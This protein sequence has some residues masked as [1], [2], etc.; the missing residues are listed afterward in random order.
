MATT[1]EKKY[2][3]NP[4]YQAAFDELQK[5][6]IC[7]MRSNDKV[8]YSIHQTIERLQHLV[9]I[10]KLRNK[11]DPI[12][13][14]Y[15]ENPPSASSVHALPS[16]TAKTSILED[17]ARMIEIYNQYFYAMDRINSITSKNLDKLG[18]QDISDDE[19]MQWYRGFLRFNKA[20]AADFSEEVR[21][22]KSLS[23]IAIAQGKTPQVAPKAAAEKELSDSEKVW[24]FFLF[25]IIIVVYMWYKASN[26]AE[27]T[28]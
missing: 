1:L 12:A 16:I 19:D 21:A 28:P 27:G 20:E 15:Q 3:V 23:D 22:L 14:K 10:V 7:F 9:V 5:E 24:F 6:T 13:T 4:D 8:I 2:T 25:C 11:A 26:A 18:T 17:I